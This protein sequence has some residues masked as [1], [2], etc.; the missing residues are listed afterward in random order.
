M[1]MCIYIYIYVYI[2][3][4][5]IYIY[6]YIYILCIYIFRGRNAGCSGWWKSTCP[7]LSVSRVDLSLSVELFGGVGIDA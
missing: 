7:R 3:Y 5:R 4:E 6:I 1:Y 2:I